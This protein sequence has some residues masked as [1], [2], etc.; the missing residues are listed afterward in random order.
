MRSGRRA[1]RAVHLTETDVKQPLP[2]L[3]RAS[4]TRDANRRAAQL[5]ADK[6]RRPRL[7]MEELAEAQAATDAKTARL[8]AQR[9]EKERQDAV[10]TGASEAELPADLVKTKLKRVRRINCA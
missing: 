2:P 10:V 6:A 3:S 4:I 5:F 7:A 1:L 9:L 8:R